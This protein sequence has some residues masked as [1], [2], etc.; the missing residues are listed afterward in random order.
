VSRTG[1]MPVRTS[2]FSSPELR[3]AN[4]LVAHVDKQMRYPVYRFAAPYA[5]EV[6][7][8]FGNEILTVVKL[9]KDAE[10]AIEDSVK[11]RQGYRQA[12]SVDMSCILWVGTFNVSL[13][14]SN[15]YGCSGVASECFAEVVGFG[16]T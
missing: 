7:N 1:W 14:Y 9:E 10:Q 5:E 2:V 12:L 11:D 16:G 3:E 15:I 13:P 4:P 8:M 6:I